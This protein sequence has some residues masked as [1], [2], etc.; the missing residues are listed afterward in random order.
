MSLLRINR[1]PGPR[2]LRVFAVAATVFCGAWAWICWRRGWAPVTS[3]LIVVGALAVLVGGMR[4]MWLRGVYVGLCYLTFPIGWV[5]SHVILAVIYFAVFTPIGLL[6]RACGHDSLARRFDP[7]ATTY[8]QPRA[9]RAPHAESY[10][11]QH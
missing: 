10:F 2:T 5:V 11:R 9:E 3:G 8:W 1:H 4:P 7:K 6:L